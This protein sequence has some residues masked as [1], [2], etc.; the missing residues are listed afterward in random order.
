MTVTNL[1]CGC[2]LRWGDD[3]GTDL[4]FCEEHD[5]EYEKWN[6]TDL[7]FIRRVATPN[8]KRRAAQKVLVRLITK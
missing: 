7:E 8:Y 5:V 3:A 4:S 2:V 1:P 6:G